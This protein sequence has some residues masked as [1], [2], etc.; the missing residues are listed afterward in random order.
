MFI[1]II[2]EIKVLRISMKLL[3]LKKFVKL[4]Y[5]RNKKLISTTD[6]LK[7][8]SN[9]KITCR[10]QWKYIVPWNKI[11]QIISTYQI[12]RTIINLLFDKIYL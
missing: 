3:I 8:E 4:L 1:A 10:L 11:N 7:L 5:N 12:W 9:W 6:S 2:F